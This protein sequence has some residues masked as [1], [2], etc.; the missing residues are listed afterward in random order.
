MFGT[1][2]GGTRVAARSVEYSYP[3]SEIAYSQCKSI[4]PKPSSQKLELARG[5]SYLEKLRMNNGLE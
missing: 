3:R 4:P 2:S 5:R 1:A